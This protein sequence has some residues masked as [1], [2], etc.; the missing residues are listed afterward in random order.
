MKIRFPERERSGRTVVNVKNLGFSFEDKVKHKALTLEFSICFLFRGYVC[1][2]QYH[3]FLYFWVDF[4]LTCLFY[5]QVLF[6]NAN[7]TIERGEKIAIIGP[8]GC[9]K[10]TFLKLIMG[11]LKPTQGEVVLGE[12]NVLP[13]YF[14]QNQVCQSFQFS[15]DLWQLFLSCCLLLHDLVCVNLCPFFF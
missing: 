3:C 6:K 9:G 5:W 8:N 11:L 13:N 2:N 1:D 10:S 14:E 15:F 7:L 12:H 4:Y